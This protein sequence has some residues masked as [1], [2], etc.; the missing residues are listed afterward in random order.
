MI[1]IFSVEQ[2]YSTG[3]VARWLN[4]KK[5]PFIRINENDEVLIMKLTHNN[6]IFKFKNLTYSL[7]EFKSVWYRRGNFNVNIL[8]PQVKKKNFLENYNRTETEEIQYYIHNLFATKRNLNNYNLIH[9]N[10]LD[11]LRYCKENG[12]NDSVFLVTQC[13]K[14]LIN[15]Y[16]DE[17]SLI[18]KAVNTPFIML[19]GHK[20]YFSYTY[21]LD[22]KDLDYFHLG[23]HW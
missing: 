23:N 7:S 18:S 16:K 9:V 5:Q 12:L 19:T 14:E 17:K 15:F 6:L 8:S 20:N 1:L 13:K 4:H 21:Q 10:K 3:Q 11:V 22:D 2:D